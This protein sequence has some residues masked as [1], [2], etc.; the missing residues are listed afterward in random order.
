MSILQSSGFSQ[1][2]SYVFPVVRD[3]FVSAKTLRTSPSSGQAAILSQL[4]DL[5]PL[6][7]HSGAA[8]A[9]MQVPRL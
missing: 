4:R 3:I 7:C 6:A 8:Y 9:P 1:G 2:I 5:K